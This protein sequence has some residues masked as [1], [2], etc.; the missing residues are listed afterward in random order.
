MGFLASMQSL[1][2][3]CSMEAQSNFCILNLLQHVSRTG[4]DVQGWACP[5]IN[6]P[7]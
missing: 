7:E 1:L 4:A 3:R 5:V 6:F 2:E